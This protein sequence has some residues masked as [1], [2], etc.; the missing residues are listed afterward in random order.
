MKILQIVYSGLGGNSSVAFSLVEGQ[1]SKKY[2]NFFIFTGVE[3]IKKSYLLKCRD[4]NIKY[5]YIKKKKFEI[6]YFKIQNI[7]KKISPDVAIIHDYSV[8]PLKIL[9]LKNKKIIY[10]H[11]TPDIT[12]RF[13]DWI[14][15]VI[16]AFFSDRIILVSKRNKKDLMSKINK[17][18]YSN[19]VKIIENGINSKRFRK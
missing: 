5:F 12:K 13:I 14:S 16:N 9:R 4:L 10:V 15:Y 2:K 7:V 19:K 3:K 18:L 11:H 1:I 17:F 6:N 8:L